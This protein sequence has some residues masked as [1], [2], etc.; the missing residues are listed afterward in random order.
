ME[1]QTHVTF[2]RQRYGKELKNI[3]DADMQILTHS[4][5]LELCLPKLQLP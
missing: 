4:Q 5:T 1:R 3:H 2:L